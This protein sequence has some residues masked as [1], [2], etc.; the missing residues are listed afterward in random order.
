MTQSVAWSHQRQEG[1]DE[2]L[3]PPE[4]IRVLGEF[5][6][7]PCSPIQRPWDTA[8]KH[9]TL[10]EDG[11]LQDWFGRVWL[12]PP[13][14]I[15]TA[16][17]LRRLAEHGDGIALIFA[18]TETQ[19]FHDYVWSKADAILFLR[20]RLTF[21]RVDGSKPEYNGGSPSCLVAYG[22]NNVVALDRSGIAGKLVCLTSPQ[23]SRKS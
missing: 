5:D 1:K 6:L 8:R 17:W 9:Y 23:P 10:I 21:Y 11:L 18:R 7:D 22:A 3:T 19:M 13:Y 20:G 14:G 4:I 12:N 2:W 15:E 16:R